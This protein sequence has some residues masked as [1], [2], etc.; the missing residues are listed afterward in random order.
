M[1]DRLSVGG[2]GW[3][4]G[5]SMDEALIRVEPSNPHLQRLYGASIVFAKRAVGALRVSSVKRACSRVHL[6]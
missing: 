2:F 1:S 3:A 4:D 5:R 6:A